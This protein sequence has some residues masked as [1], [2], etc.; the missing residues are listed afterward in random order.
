MTRT[1]GIPIFHRTFNRNIGDSR[2]LRDL[3]TSFKNFD[4]NFAVIIYDR[5]VT[6]ASNIKEIKKLKLDTI[7]GVPSNNNLKKILK[8]I[9]AENKIND[10]KNRIKINESIFYCIGYHGI[11][12]RL[13][14]L[15]EFPVC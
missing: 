6:S 8:K 3:I 11:G 4:I 15:R 1:E 7:C 13:S 5:G 2:T 14:N 9:V 12:E 10:I